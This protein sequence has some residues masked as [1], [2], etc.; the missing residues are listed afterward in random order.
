MHYG[1][2]NPQLMRIHAD[3][4]RELSLRGESPEEYGGELVGYSPVPV[5]KRKPTPVT[6]GGGAGVLGVGY[7][8]GSF[9]IFLVAFL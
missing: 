6:R 8:G 1:R 3:D 5:P 7:R 2:P 9:R 4:V